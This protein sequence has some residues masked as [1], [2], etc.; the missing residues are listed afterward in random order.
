MAPVQRLSGQ[1]KRS[2]VRWSPSGR[3]AVAIV[4]SNAWSSFIFDS[5]DAIQRPVAVGT[6]LGWKTEAIS[7]DDRLGL[8]SE[9]TALWLFQLL[10]E[11]RSRASALGTNGA[12]QR[13]QGLVQHPRVGVPLELGALVWW[14]EFSADGRWLAAGGYAPGDANRG[15]AR[16]WRVDTGVP[17]SPVL[18]HGGTVQA[19][20]F[21]PD[22][23]WLVTA[24]GTQGGLPARARIWEVAPGIEVSPGLPHPEGIIRVRYAPDGRTILTACSDGVARMWDASSHQPKARPMRHDRG[25][26]DLEF[27]PDG[28]LIATASM[29]STARLWDAATGDPV[30][31]PFRHGGPVRGVEFLPDGSSI[32]TSSEDGTVRVW[33]LPTRLA[34]RQDIELAAAVLSGVRATPTGD[35]EPLSA[36][37]QARWYH[38]LRKAGRTPAAGAGR[39]AE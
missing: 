10:P 26:E 39:P 18:L 8:A 32:V 38:E 23:R 20:A 36:S 25:I 24:P 15:L 31:A 16:L 29:D 30:G 13:G 34:T 5:I 21:S 6:G 3:L 19:L 14:A 27:S 1:H 11:V 2:G 28:R 9:G 17:A 35:S 22:S 37:D 7:P 4:Y 33:R 12:F